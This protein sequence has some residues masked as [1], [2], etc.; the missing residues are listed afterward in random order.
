MVFEKRRKKNEKLSSLRQL[1]GEKYV[2]PSFTTGI[3]K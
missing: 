2:K 3:Y 1:N